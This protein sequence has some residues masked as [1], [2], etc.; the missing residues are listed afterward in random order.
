MLLTYLAIT[1]TVAA[2]S[3]L[4]G[5]MGMAGG[6]IL[7]AILISLQPV[8]TAMV[9]HGVVQ[10]V[11]N[12]SRTLF[13]LRHV[14]W[15]LLPPYLVG[16]SVALAAFIALALV[17]DQATVLIVIG[18]FP[19]LARVLPRLN[20]LDVT[21]PVT[22]ATS[23]LVVTTAQLFAGVSGPL[24]DIFYLQARLNRYQ[25]IA[26]KA[27]TQTLGHLLKLFYYGVLISMEEAVPVWFLL[28]AVVA[29][30][31]GTRIG[32][33]LLTGFTDA[34]FRR[35]TG[36]VILG[37]GTLCMVEGVRQLIG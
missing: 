14:Y 13:L 31:I 26:T 1:A 5:V 36:W 24:L 34:Q 37:I 15:A 20:R 3:I 25:I 19:W 33:G 10:A 11:A 8:A 12:G 27:L 7:M 6:L 18:A 32:T 35:V 16:A 28:A 29:A 4:S 2:T 9:V 22:A 17:P 23:G 21:R 30:V